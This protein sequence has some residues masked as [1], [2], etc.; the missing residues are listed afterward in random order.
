MAAGVIIQSLNYEKII[1]IEKLIACD[2]AERMKSTGG[3]AL[4]SFVKKANLSY[5]QRTTL[6]F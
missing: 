6:T 2:V 1:N 3:F 4:P 5:L